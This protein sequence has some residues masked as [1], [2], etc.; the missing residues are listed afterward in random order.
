MDVGSFRLAGDCHCAGHLDFAFAGKSQ[1]IQF[2]I[3]DRVCRVG[4]DGTRADRDASV[5]H[6]SERIDG[7][8]SA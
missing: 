1:Q 3:L 4:R 8:G 6:Q 2:E 5:V 7:G